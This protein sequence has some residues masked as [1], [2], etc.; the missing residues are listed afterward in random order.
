MEPAI[1]LYHVWHARAFPLVKNKDKKTI[2]KTFHLWEPPEP[3]T[4]APPVTAGWKVYSLAQCKSSL[5]KMFL[6]FFLYCL[7]PNFSIPAR[8][9]PCVACRRPTNRFKLFPSIILTSFHKC[10][11]TVNNVWYGLG[12]CIIEGRSVT[13]QPD[14]LHVFP[15]SPPITMPPSHSNHPPTIV[16]DF[17]ISHAPSDGQHR[18]HPPSNRCPTWVIPRD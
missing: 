7:H 4:D 18:R 9:Y 10:M 3:L 17:T 12:S 2:E 13:S 11:F 1:L 8:L 16:R 5:S 14:D 6:A 15:M